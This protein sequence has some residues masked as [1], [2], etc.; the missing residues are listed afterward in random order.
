M[1]QNNKSNIIYLVIIYTHTVVKD[2]S[3][4]K[5]EKVEIKATILNH[6]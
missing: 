1:K 6:P 5:C 4:Y 3:N 2:V